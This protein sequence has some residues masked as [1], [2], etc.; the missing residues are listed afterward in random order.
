MPTR[1]YFGFLSVPGVMR[2][3]AAEE[4]CMEWEYDEPGTI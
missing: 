4:K 2:V 1:F 3:S